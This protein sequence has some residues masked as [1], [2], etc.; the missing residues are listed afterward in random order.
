MRSTDNFGN[1]MAN[2]SEAE[3]IKNKKVDFKQSLL[4]EVITKKIQKA[5]NDEMEGF[6]LNTFRLILIIYFF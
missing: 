1:L 2:E 6:S 4:E 3:I 5:K